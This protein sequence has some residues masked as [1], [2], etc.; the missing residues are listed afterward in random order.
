MKNYNKISHFSMLNILLRQSKLKRKSR[1]IV[2]NVITTQLIL[3]VF[4]NYAGRN[5]WWS[6][7]I[8]FIYC[9]SIALT[10]YNR[11]P[12]AHTSAN[13]LPVAFY[14][15]QTWGFFRT[16][17]VNLTNNSIITNL[18]SMGLYFTPVVFVF[19]F[20]VAMRKGNSI[21]YHYN[22]SDDFDLIETET[23]RNNKY[24]KILAKAIA[25]IIQK[26]KLR[27]IRAQ[28]LR[29]DSSGY[30]N[31]GHEFRMVCHGVFSVEN[32][33]GLLMCLLL[34]AR[35]WKEANI[36]FSK[37]SFF[38]ISF[39]VEELEPVYSDYIEILHHS[40]MSRVFW[41]LKHLELHNF[42]FYKPNF[43]FLMKVIDVHP[44]I[45]I[46][47][48]HHNCLISTNENIRRREFVNRIIQRGVGT[49]EM[50]EY[51]KDDLNAI[52]NIFKGNPNL[53][54]IL[55]TLDKDLNIGEY[56]KRRLKT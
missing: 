51:S 9:L 15:T 48:I 32:G 55:C 7:L 21:W 54:K 24:N 22:E 11:F 33:H 10:H 35:L 13:Y 43:L 1:Q 25:E 20:L 27:G 16:F 28:I 50:F 19:S 45:E 30:S 4:S 42:V 12:Y 34:L 18:S 38:N 36:Y 53:R 44:A 5:Q 2:S 14:F 47:D 31:S 29:V 41:F 49:G 40:L 37:I 3:L 17:M 6:A 39:Y 8:C 23:D 56:L 46:L 26:L 52:R